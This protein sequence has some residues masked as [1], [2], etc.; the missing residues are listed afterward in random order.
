MESLDMRPESMGPGI[1]LIVG[2]VATVAIEGPILWYG[3]SAS[4]SKI[5]RLT[6][7]FWLTACTY[8]I[9]VLVVPSIDL[10]QSRGGYLLVAESFAVLGEC[11][12]F[13]VLFPVESLRSRLRDVSVVAIAN[14][15]SFLLG[16]LW[17][18]M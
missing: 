3:L 8:P 11:L 14:L 18:R 7:A 9:V 5:A 13:T 17:W 1:F 4:H 2:Y 12:L 16:E 6:A 15:T 10:S